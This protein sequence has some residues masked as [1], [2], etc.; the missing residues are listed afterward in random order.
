M[1][2]HAII[3]RRLRAAVRRR[4]LSAAA[5]RIALIVTSSAKAAQSIAVTVHRLVTQ[6]AASNIGIAVIR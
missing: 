2:A 6:L 3:A 4:L 1:H 5:A